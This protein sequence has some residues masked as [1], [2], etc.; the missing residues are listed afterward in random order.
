MSHQLTDPAARIRVTSVPPSP[1]TRRAWLRAVVVLVLFAASG[2]A[3]GVWWEHLWHP[4]QGTVVRHEWFVVD[5]EFRYDLDG[6]RNQFSGT[7]LFVVMALGGGALLGALTALLTRRDE[8]LTLAVVGIGSVVA[9]LLMWQV[10]TRLGPPDPH[11]LALSAKRGTVLPDHLALGSPGA[12][13]AWPFSALVA[14]C[15]VFLLIPGR[16]RE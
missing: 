5:E 8:L 12:L 4:S 6:L 1:E 15:A 11:V 7:G 2:A 14:L 9:A 13:L 3:L 16:H 10:G